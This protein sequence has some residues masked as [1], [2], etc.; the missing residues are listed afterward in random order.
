MVRRI[1]PLV[2]GQK[3]GLYF[4]ALFAVILTSFFVLPIQVVIVGGGALALIFIAMFIWLTAL[5][6]FSFKTNP[7]V[8]S[9]LVKW[10]MSTIIIVILSIGFLKDLGQRMGAELV[11]HGVTTQAIV[12]DK[13]VNSLNTSAPTF[14]LTVQYTNERNETGVQHFKTSLEDF[15]AID[16]NQMI[17][18]RYSRRYPSL[19]MLLQNNRV[20]NPQPDLS[21][22]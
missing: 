13:E 15:N 20:S 17:L 21:G 14:T 10:V 3:T 16:V 4:A 5:F 9:K 18:V 2:L 19:M 22:S 8:Y 6:V 11:Q 12:L 7:N 1:G